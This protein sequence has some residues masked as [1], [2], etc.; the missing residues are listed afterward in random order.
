MTFLCA[1]SLILERYT[2]VEASSSNNVFSI[3]VAVQQTACNREVGLWLC[4]PNPAA[5]CCS[6]SGFV[7]SAP[8]AH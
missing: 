7:H 4:F 1:A 2:N 5:V 3:A 6:S 8:A